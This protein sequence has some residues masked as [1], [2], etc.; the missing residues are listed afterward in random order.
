LLALGLA[1]SAGAASTQLGPIRHVHDVA[2]L[3]NA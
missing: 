2:R 3:L 1:G